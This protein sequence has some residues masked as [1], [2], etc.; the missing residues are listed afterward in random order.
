ML[1]LY[2]FGPNFGLSDPS[3]FVLKVETY[4]LMA[5]IDYESIS[6]L[7]NLSKAPKGKL[8]FI[9]NDGEIIADSQFIID[10]LEKKYNG[11][12]DSHLS[13]EQKALTYLI[14]KSLDENLYF[15]LVYSRW[16]CDETWPKVKNT[17]FGKFPFPLKLIIPFIARRGVIRTLK[18]QGISRH[19]KQEVE[20]ICLKTFQALSSLISNKPYILGDQPCSLDATVFAF[21]AEFILVDLD[22][23]FNDI[24]RSQSTLTNYCQRIYKTYYL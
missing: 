5:N 4:L 16:Q 11:R 15:A 23:T 18:G 20:Q 2:S 12:L 6:R 7:N 19:S 10:Y 3:P 14:T 17:F 1:K 13:D 21:L 8:P 9:E 24:A 22:N